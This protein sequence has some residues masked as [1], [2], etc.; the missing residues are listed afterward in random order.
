MEILAKQSGTSV[1]MIEQHYSHVVPKMFTQELSGV[2]ITTSKPKKKKQQSPDKIALK[3]KGLAQELKEW[4][5]EYKKR[6]CI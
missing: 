2:D 5:V 3:H 6:G 4:E 1:Q